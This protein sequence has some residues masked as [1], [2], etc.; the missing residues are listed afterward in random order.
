LSPPFSPPHPLLR[1]ALCRR[2]SRRHSYRAFTERSLLPI[3]P[4]SPLAVGDTWEDTFEL[5]QVR[6]PGF[7]K[8]HVK[9]KYAGPSLYKNASLD[10]ITTEATLDWGKTPPGVAVKVVSQENPGVIYFDSGV[11]R[12]MEIR[13]SQKR[14]VEGIGNLI[15]QL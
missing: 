6:G 15:S 8:A 7:Q 3:L 9:Y 14:T 10:K 1:V 13:N 4:E 12:L 11:G 5:K 2:V